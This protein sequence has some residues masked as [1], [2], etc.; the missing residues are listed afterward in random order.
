MEKLL[1]YPLAIEWMWDYCIYLGAFTNSEGQNFD[2]GVY[3]DNNKIV[4]AAIVYGD[5]AGQYL[6]G[7]L[8]VFG[9]T[10]EVWSEVYKET[11]SRLKKYNKQHEKFRINFF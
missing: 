7:H 1:Y 11:R 6:S 9:Y 8:D 10:D 4:S 2:L 3:I 5:E